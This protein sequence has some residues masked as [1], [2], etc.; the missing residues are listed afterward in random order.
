MEPRQGW[1]LDPGGRHH[2]RWFVAGLPTFRV[3]TAGIESVDPVTG[4]VAQ[5]A[6]TT[7]SVREGWWEDPIGRHRWRW[8][9]AGIPS[10]LVRDD[11][12]GTDPLA[13]VEL[14]D[15]TF[16][17]SSPAP[18]QPGPPLPPPPSVGSDVRRRRYPRSAAVQRAGWGMLALVVGVG[19]ILA[20]DTP[21][22]RTGGTAGGIGAAV[23]VGS[24]CV[25]VGVVL[26]SL[27]VRAVLSATFRERRHLRR[28]D[29]PGGGPP[30]H[31]V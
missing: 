19:I 28:E 9:S 1:H 16:A 6:A 4:A 21:L 26:L 23:A 11:E 30:R 10:S 20:R 12:V 8:Y 14:V 22:R 15:A 25:A 27:S 7:P 29:P 18:E 24:V 2:E 31:P 3:R 13:D 5:M 17:A